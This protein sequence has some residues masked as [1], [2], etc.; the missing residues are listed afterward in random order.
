MQVLD[1]IFGGLLKPIDR[2]Q[3]GA[4]VERHNGNA[5]DKSFKS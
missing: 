2:R 4:I 3:F 1:S 5:Y